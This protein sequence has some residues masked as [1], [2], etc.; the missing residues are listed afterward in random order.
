LILDKVK[1][2]RR[3]QAEKK[4]N[5]T[6]ATEIAEDEIILNMLDLEKRSIELSSFNMNDA[7]NKIPINEN[8]VYLKTMF[9]ESNNEES[10]DGSCDDEK[11]NYKRNNDPPI[12]D[13]SLSAVANVIADATLTIRAHILE[14]PD[15]WIADTGATSH[16]TKHTEG[17][18][19][20][21]QTNVWTHGFVGE[22]IQPDCEMDIPVTYVDVNG[23]EKFN[24][25][26]GDVQTNE[27]FNYN[28]FSV[29]KMLLKG[30]KL[31]GDKHL[32]TMWNQTQP[33]VF[34]LVI[35]EKIE[36]FSVLSSQEIYAN[37]RW[38]TQSFKQLRAVQI[39]Q[40]K[41]SR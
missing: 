25:V 20:H 37:Q 18:R 34:D 22:T 14:S 29:T 16:V 3:K 4:A 38:Q 5:S 27:K 41:Y 13:L 35:R 32:I 31:K 8:I 19:K 23:T 7:F 17:G 30:C 39:L 36:H 33:I 1:A 9:K 28:L 11:S 6:A 10:N 40:R 15:I 26:L 12:L 2:A 24:I 21:R